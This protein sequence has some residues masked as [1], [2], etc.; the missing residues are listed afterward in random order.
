MKKFGNEKNKKE[1]D[2]KCQVAIEQDLKA[3]GQELDED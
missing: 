1:G 3:M 2:K